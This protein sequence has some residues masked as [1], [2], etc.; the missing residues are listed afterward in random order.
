M[1]EWDVMDDSSPIPRVSD[2]ECFAHEVLVECHVC[3][4][5]VVVTSGGQPYAVLPPEWR[6]KNTSQGNRAFCG[7]CADLIP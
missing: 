3:G 6:I 5:N 2:G 1:S 7:I 4:A